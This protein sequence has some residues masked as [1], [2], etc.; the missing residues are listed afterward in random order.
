VKL[1]SI[2]AQ[3]LTWKYKAAGI[4]LLIIGLAWFI[5]WRE[6][7]IYEDGKDAGQLELFEAEK[8]QLEDMTAKVREEIALQQAAVDAEQSA[9]TM[10]RLALQ[11]QRQAINQTLKQ[12]IATIAGR[13]PE[14]R[15]ELQNVPASALDARLRQS[16]ARAREADAELARIR[17]Q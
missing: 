17:A 15:Y 8:K 2:P 3:F 12:G 6:A 4:G 14:I 7:R 16:L 5:K 1:F 11:G 9:L 10:E 13:D